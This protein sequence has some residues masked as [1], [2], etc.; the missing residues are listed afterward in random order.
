LTK[1]QWK[2]L[3]LTPWIRRSVSLHETRPPQRNQISIKGSQ[4]GRQVNPSTKEFAV[5]VAVSRIIA[6]RPIEI[7]DGSPLKNWNGWVLTSH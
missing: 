1:K 3:L 7:G 6:P 2:L 5:A 4:I